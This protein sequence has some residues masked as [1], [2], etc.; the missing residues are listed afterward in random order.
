MAT[1]F[2]RQR[3]DVGRRAGRPRFTVVGVEGSGLKFFRPN[4]RRAELDVIAESINAQIVML[5]RG[6][7]EHNDEEEGASRRIAETTET[8]D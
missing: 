4:L 6:S 1:I 5:P 3:R 2:V 8:F 7:G